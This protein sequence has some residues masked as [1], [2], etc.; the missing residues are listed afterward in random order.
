MTESQSIS[1]PHYPRLLRRIRAALIDSVIISVIVLSWWL[2]LP[3]LEGLPPLARLAYPVVAILAVE[4]V[5]VS[6][7]GGSP[8]HHIMGVAIHDAQNRRRIGIIRA[9]LRF[10]TRTML[11]WLSLILVLITKKHQALHDL[12]CRTNVI[13]LHPDNLPDREKLV[14]RVTEDPQFKYPSKIR[15][16]FVIVIY[17]VLILV[18]VSVISAVSLSESCLWANQ[19]NQL[20]AIIALILNGG[21]VFGVGSS[22]VLGWQARLIGCSRRRIESVDAAL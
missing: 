17:I 3:L 13:L 16:T 15:R 10:V 2:M 18:L 8:G 19:C 7:T 14:E 1:S 4:P 5:M 20:D 22:I 21:F 12:I 11:G 9:L 6:F